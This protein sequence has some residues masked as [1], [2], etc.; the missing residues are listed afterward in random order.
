M[1]LRRRPPAD[2]MTRGLISA[3]RSSALTRRSLN[4]WLAH[5]DLVASGAAGGV[6]LVTHDVDEALTLAHRVV[7]LSARPGRVLADLPTGG[8]TPEATADLRRRILG[9]LGV[10]AA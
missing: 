1:A 2:P 10:A 3:A 7:V 5:A 6:V 8:R 4:A 9:L